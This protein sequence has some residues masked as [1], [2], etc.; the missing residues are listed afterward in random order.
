MNNLVIS[1]IMN[2]RSTRSFKEEQIT[3]FE[4]DAILQCGLNAPS[5]YNNQSWYFTVV[6]N[7]ILLNEINEEVRKIIIN[8]GDERRS[9]MA[10]QEGYNIF[11]NAPTVIFVSMEKDEPF[12]QTNCAMAIENMLLAAESQDVGSCVIGLVRLAFEGE[13][14]DYLLEKLDIA[15]AVYDPLCAV[16]FG[17]KLGISLPRDRLPNK[18]N[19]IR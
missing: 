15:R 2:R 12:T 7:Q 9:N 4:L 3:R 8:S 16:S 5:A 19:F 14:R 6:Q 17:Y 1:N 18:V 13:R 11:H 10:K